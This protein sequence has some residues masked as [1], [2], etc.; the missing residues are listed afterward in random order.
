MKDLAEGIRILASQMDRLKKA[1]KS[2][3]LRATISEFPRMM[4]EVVDFI[5]K[6]LESWSGVYSILWDGL[7]TELLA[8]AKHILVLPHK[9]KAIESQRNLDELRK[10]FVVDLIQEVQIGQGLVFAPIVIA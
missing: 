9:D 5:E 6:W 4:K 1:P 3:E 10:R 2:E 8:A 7:T